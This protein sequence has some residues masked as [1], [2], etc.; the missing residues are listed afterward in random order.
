MK[1]QSKLLAK[2]KT[3]WYFGRSIVIIAKR[4]R[5]PNRQKRVFDKNKCKDPEVGNRLIQ[6]ISGKETKF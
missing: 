2:W 3:T 5:K 1:S 6:I 4:K